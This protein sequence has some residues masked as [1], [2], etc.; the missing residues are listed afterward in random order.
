MPFLIEFLLELII[1]VFIELIFKVV[2]VGV[3]CFCTSVI[4]FLKNKIIILYHA[5]IDFLKLKSN[6]E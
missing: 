6:D 5:V 1:Y 2:I 3:Y 4:S